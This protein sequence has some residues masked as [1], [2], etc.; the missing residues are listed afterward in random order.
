MKTDLTGTTIGNEGLIVTSSNASDKGMAYLG[1][2]GSGTYYLK[3][4]AGRDGYNLLTEPIT[5][6]IGTDGTVS[7][8]QS[9]YND[10][11]KGPDLVYK[12]KDGKF[13]YYSKI[14]KDESDVYKDDND[15]TFAG[16]RII[17]SNMSGVEL[18]ATG[19]SGTR[20]FTIL[21]SI[22]ILGA[23]FLLLQRRRLT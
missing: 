1:S 18:P 13:Y 9:I 15:Y 4:I 20:L 2:L 12:D 22:L 8:T 17:V 14:R 23:G 6:T 19:G 5:I 11:A 16:Y 3:E 21:G 7:Y 10:S